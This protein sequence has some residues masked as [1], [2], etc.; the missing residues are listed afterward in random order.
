MLSNKTTTIHGRDVDRAVATHGT[1]TGTK[2]VTEG[3][4]ATDPDMK[5][6]PPHMLTLKFFVFKD[7]ETAKRYSLALEPEG[8]SWGK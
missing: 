4:C 7:K 6:N 2:I 3:I 5:S 1:N 8:E